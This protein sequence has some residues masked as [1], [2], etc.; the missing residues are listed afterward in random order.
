MAHCT[1]YEEENKRSELKTS[2]QRAVQNLDNACFHTL[3][4]VATKIARPTQTAGA[5]GLVLYS[6]A[7]RTEMGRNISEECWGHSFPAWSRQL[8]HR[9]T[10]FFHK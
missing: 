8:K 10:A 9:V 6:K 4:V 1:N 7:L 5:M 2:W 3:F